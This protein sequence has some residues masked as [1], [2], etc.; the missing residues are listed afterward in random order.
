MGYVLLL[1]DRRARAETHAVHAAAVNMQ[2]I[3]DLFSREC[4]S[5]EQRVFRVN[6]FV[7]SRVPEKDRRDTPAHL[8]FQRHAPAHFR[9]ILRT[10]KVMD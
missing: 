2:L 6:H 1:A 5:K 7:R 8:R 9:R 10:E 4:R 3:G